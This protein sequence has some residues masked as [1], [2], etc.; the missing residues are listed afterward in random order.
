[1]TKIEEKIKLYQ[2][3]PNFLIEDFWYF[4]F[5]KKEDIKNNVFTDRTYQNYIQRHTIEGFLD[6]LSLL[7]WKSHNYYFYTNEDLKVFLENDNYLNSLKWENWFWYKFFFSEIIDDIIIIELINKIK[8]KKDKI[9]VW[10]LKY[11][12][13]SNLKNR[14]IEHKNIIE[15]NNIP[16]FLI[17][18]V[19]WADFLLLSDKL[20]K[21]T[22]EKE[23]DILMKYVVKLEFN[24]NLCEKKN[25]QWLKT[26]Y[27]KVSIEKL[28]N[29]KSNFFLWG[30]NIFQIIDNF[31][32][33]L[34]PGRLYDS[35]LFNLLSND[36]DDSF[37]ERK[38]INDKL[39]LDFME[40]SKKVITE[41]WFQLN[42]IFDLSLWN[43]LTFFSQFNLDILN[44][45]PKN[46]NDIS[47][48]NVKEE[49]QIKNIFLI[50]E[51]FFNIFDATKNYHIFDKY[52][53]LIN[54]N[55]ILD[56]EKKPINQIELLEDEK[57]IYYIDSIFDLIEDNIL[58]KDNLP[59]TKILFNFYTHTEEQ[60]K[61]YRL[62][63]NTIIGELLNELKNKI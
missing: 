34:F 32:S 38:R 44:G 51:N 37:K 11:V 31:M 46:I 24:L 8:N 2:K 35:W 22:I 20:F 5:F 59:Y 23:W 61:E 39:V 14:L 53:Y 13:L 52:I 54:L 58:K 60:A 10:F 18:I 25:Y 45:L 56:E 28:N 43:L 6:N 16:L 36:I 49:S 26:D 15:A 19:E 50:K 17:P 30:G 55:S 33:S 47:N 27:K 41:E 9:R 62:Y 57:E 63:L 40:Y 1:M 29:V 12:S 48:Q 4:N 42:P 7:Q 3:E 21:R